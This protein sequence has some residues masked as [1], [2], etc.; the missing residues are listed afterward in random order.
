MNY[1]KYLYYWF[2][3]KLSNLG[4]WNL[5]GCAHFAVTMIIMANVFSFL[6]LVEILWFKIILFKYVIS[7]LFL[8]LFILNLFIFIY[9]KKYITII[10]Q[11]NK[12]KTKR[13]KGNVVVIIYLLITFLSFLI[14]F[15][16]GAKR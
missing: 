7:K 12:H 13:F 10:K 15:S 9:K 1:Y 4:D 11:F 2:Y 16:I 8:I 14:V 3:K 6:L 5:E